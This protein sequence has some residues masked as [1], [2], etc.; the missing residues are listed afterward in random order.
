MRWYRRHRRD[1][2]ESP[3]TEEEIKRAQKQMERARRLI[4]IITNPPVEGSGQDNI[5]KDIK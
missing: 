4:K 2:T 5:G 1:Y 3:P